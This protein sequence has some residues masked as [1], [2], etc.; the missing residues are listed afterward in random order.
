VGIR[1]KRVNIVQ[2]LIHIYVNGKMI[3]IKTI[4]GIREGALKETG[5]SV[6]SSVI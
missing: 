5:G 3:P 4:P 2:I 6:I 1:Y